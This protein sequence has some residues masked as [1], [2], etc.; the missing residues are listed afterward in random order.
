MKKLKLILFV[1]MV[2]GVSSCGYHF[3]GGGYIHK[4]VNSVAVTVFENKS[5][6]T[7]AGIAFTNALIQQIL[8]KTDTD[9]VEQSRA[10]AVLKGTINSITFATLSRSTTQSVV[11]RRVSA[12]IDLEMF[13]REGD[14]IWSVKN[15]KSDDEYSVSDDQIVDESKQREVVEKI[16][17]RIAEK[18]I[19][20]MQS[21]F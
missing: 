20:K 1:W 8:Q 17:T 13:N 3:V 16:A 4:D 2:V 21:N 19:S 15:F 12:V 9:V 11:E 6:E 18:I 10:A 5:S 14:M 7:S